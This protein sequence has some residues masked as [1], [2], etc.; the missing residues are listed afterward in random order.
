LRPVKQAHANDQRSGEKGGRP[1]VCDWIDAIGRE[2]WRRGLAHGYPN[3]NTQ[4]AYGR[5]QAG[6]RAAAGTR[7]ASAAASAMLVMRISRRRKAHGI[8]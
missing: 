5:G 8:R 6:G 1:K 7:T 3:Q 2:S 4:R